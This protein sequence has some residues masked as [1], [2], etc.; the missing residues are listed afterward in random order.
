MNHLKSNQVLVVLITV[1]IVIVGSVLSYLSLSGTFRDSS[2]IG[3]VNLKKVFETVPVFTKKQKLWTQNRK[4]LIQNHE[5]Q[6]KEVRS[7]LEGVLS[8]SENLEQNPFE[9]SSHSH[10]QSPS[11]AKKVPT[12]VTSNLSLKTREKI[13]TLVSRKRRAEYVIQQKRREIQ[14]RGMKEIR[15]TVAKIARKQDIPL[16][17]RY[18]NTIYRDDSSLKGDEFPTPPFRDLTNSVINDLRN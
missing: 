1:S 12:E 2:T 3:I 10:K 7:E 11:S 6:L 5:A 15:Q 9:N 4:T 13:K 8:E 16:V 14:K 18:T 17:Y